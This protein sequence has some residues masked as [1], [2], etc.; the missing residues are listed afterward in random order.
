MRTK[1]Q[2]EKCQTSE[3]VFAGLNP[4]V[5]AVLWPLAKY[6]SLLFNIGSTKV[7]VPKRVTASFLI[8]WMRSGSVEVC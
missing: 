6:V 5:G 7:N 4:N 2:S 1:H 8:L 3:Q